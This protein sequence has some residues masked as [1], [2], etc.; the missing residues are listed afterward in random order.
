MFVFPAKAVA[1]IC[2]SVYMLATVSEISKIPKGSCF[3]K[4]KYF[5][6][7]NLDGLLFDDVLQVTSV[8]F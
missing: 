2:L 5:K 1:Y 7:K 3:R 4:I 6:N 8:I